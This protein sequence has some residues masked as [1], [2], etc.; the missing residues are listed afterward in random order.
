M[1][2]PAIQSLLS[3]L[4]TQIAAQMYSLPGAWQ[5]MVR[6]GNIDLN[7]RPVVRNPDGS[8][9]TVRSVSFRVGGHEVL[10]PTVINGAVV[11]NRVALEHYYKTGQNLGS[12][13]DPPSANAYAE[14]LHQQQA[15][16]YGR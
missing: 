14:A 10:I 11:S 8:I 13:R 4:A 12:F 1:G 15:R 9:S 7:A 3:P 16:A 5:G 2:N 6:P